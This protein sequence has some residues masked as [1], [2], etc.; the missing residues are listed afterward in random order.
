MNKSL[1]IF[2]DSSGSMAEM[3]KILLQRNLCRF[4]SQLPNIDDRYSKLD[5]LFYEWNSSITELSIQSD[6]DIPEIFPQNTADLKVIGSF[7]CD[8]SM[9]DQKKAISALLL[10]DGGFDNSHISEFNSMING[11]SNLKLQFVAVGAD[12]NIFK[13]EK[14]STSHK[15]YFAEDISGSVSSLMFDYSNDVAAPLSL[16][17]L[18]LPTEKALEEDWDA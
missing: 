6:G 9:K 17:E 5:L 16:N 10:T 3:G 14:I 1:Y 13:L 7:L 4:I 11:L 15:V 8:L 2:I 12:A 18:R